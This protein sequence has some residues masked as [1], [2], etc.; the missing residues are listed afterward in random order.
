VTRSRIDWPRLARLAVTAL[1]ASVVGTIGGL[2][3]VA[4]A[5]YVNALTHPGCWH[6]TDGPVGAGIKE[7]QSTTPLRP[8]GLELAAW[9]VPPRNDALII[10]LGGLGSG[11]DAMLREGAILAQHGYGLLMPDYRACSNRE[12][13]STLGYLEALDLH[14]AVGWALE[15]PE[16]DQV[17][18]LGFSVGGVTAIFAAAEDKR[19]EAVVAEGG[20]ADL[21]A[22]LSGESQGG[23]LI[24]RI[25]YTLNPFLF[26]LQTGVDPSTVNPLSVID[27]ISPRPLLL[28]YGEHEADSGG[29]EQQISAAGDPK[30]LWIVPDCGHGGYVDVAPEEWERRVVGFFDE[31][32]G[33]VR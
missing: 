25:V 10:L 4:S 15:Q 2:G 31:A 32:L 6:L 16:V 29:A 23:D 14:E 3:L 17:G 19:I 1:I 24:A 8:D 18:V 21:A 11:R 9:Y 28:I 26:R 12:G 22:D 30:E 7:V 33:V 20:F 5:R 27:Q 13:G